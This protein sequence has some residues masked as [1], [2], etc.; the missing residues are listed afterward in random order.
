MGSP[1]HSPSES[2]SLAPITGGGDNG[3][4]PKLKADVL[5]FDQQLFTKL[6]NGQKDKYALNRHEN[7]E[8]S[9]FA[10]APGRNPGCLG[11]GMG[12]AIVM[13]NYTASG[14]E[15]RVWDAVWQIR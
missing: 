4:P 7:A 14:N 11:A 12:R 8:C 10:T 6:S 3:W 5:P 9:T 15:A 1:T 13:E 2:T